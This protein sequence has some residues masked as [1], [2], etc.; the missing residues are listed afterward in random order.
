[1]GLL[2]KMETYVNMAYFLTQPQERLQLNYKTTS[3]QK[4]SKEWSCME[5]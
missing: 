2:V 3:T 5:V 4:L 1:M